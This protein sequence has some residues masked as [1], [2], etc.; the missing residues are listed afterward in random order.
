MKKNSILLILLIFWIQLFCIANS[1]QCCEECI[2]DLK[3]NNYFNIRVF[4]SPW[5]SN[6]T[7]FCEST[8]NRNGTCCNQKD[9]EYYSKIW[10][11]RIE[12]SLN[13]T[14]SQIIEFDS[15]LLFLA[16]IK[17]YVYTNEKKILASKKM[18]KDELDD[19]KKSLIS[20][21]EGVHNFAFKKKA[22][23][24]N[25]KSCHLSL[26]EIRMNALCMRCSSQAYKFWDKKKKRYKVN[27]KTCVKIISSCIE[28]FAFLAQITTFFKRLT[29]IRAAV[30]GKNLEGEGAKGLKVLEINL[31][32]VCAVDPELC[33]TMKDIYEENCNYFT[34]GEMNPDIEGEVPTFKDGSRVAGMLAD[35]KDPGKNRL[36]ETGNQ[37]DPKFGYIYVDE[38][39]ADLVD[40]FKFKIMD[41]QSYGRMKEKGKIGDE[42]IKVENN[43]L[44]LGG[45]CLGWI[46]VLF[47]GL[48]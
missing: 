48:I 46:G 36:L 19:F 39:G 44:R 31:L 26:N 40:D 4:K 9:L 20:Y 25:L 23:K 11:S 33:V 6:Y 37:L 14:V 29:Q 47:L 2:A 21:H 27:K 35:G 42:G 43:F 38:K 5:I 41:F 7:G 22:L 13:N 1:Q 10:L 3:I 15:A 30:G 45:V 12:F 16:Q 34:I 17:K 18:K 24:K 8:F 32:K 28:V